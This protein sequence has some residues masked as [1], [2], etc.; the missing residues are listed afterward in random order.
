[1]EFDSRIGKRGACFLAIL[2]VLCRASAFAD[3]LT[4]YSSRSGW[5]TAAPGARV[6]TFE[7][8]TTLST[9]HPPEVVIDGVTFRGPELFTNAPAL[10]YDSPHHDSTYF[11]W[12]NPPLLNVSLPGPVHAVGFDYGTFYGQIHT[13]EFTLP[14]GETIRLRAGA[15]SNRFFGLVSPRPFDGFTLNNVT[16]NFPTMDNLSFASAAPVPEP[17]AIL[18]V[19]TG[20]VWSVR[21]LRGRTAGRKV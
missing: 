14:W 21:R 8:T 19:G 3:P 9:S 18:L 15:F 6:I 20:L 1:M 2:C 7:G 4:I 11:S 16:G 12:Q 13:L 17:G 10:D 5:N